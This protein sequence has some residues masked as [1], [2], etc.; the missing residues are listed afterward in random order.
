MKLLLFQSPSF[1]TFVPVHGVVRGIIVRGVAPAAL[2][3][4]LFLGAAFRL[5]P[6]GLRAFSASAGLLLRLL[7]FLP[8]LSFSFLS[9]LPLERELE[10]K[11]SLSS[12]L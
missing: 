2:S 8:L 7:P 1:F 9:F 6:T 11:W 3:L 4:G 5:R 10:G 12:G